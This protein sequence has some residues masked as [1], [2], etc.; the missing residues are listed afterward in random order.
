M[1]SIVSAL[2]SSFPNLTFKLFNVQLWLEDRPTLSYCL[3]CC[4][5]GY[6]QGRDLRSTVTP[7]SPNTVPISELGNSFSINKALMA[8]I[9]LLCG[10]LVFIKTF[11]KHQPVSYITDNVVFFCFFPL[12]FGFSRCFANDI[13]PLEE[14]RISPF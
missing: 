8:P 3:T 4:S 6:V 11:H 14:T 5:C 13:L 12:P 1:A 9:I 7:P 2:C 10:F